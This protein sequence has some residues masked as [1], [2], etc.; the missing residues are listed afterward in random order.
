MLNKFLDYDLD[1]IIIS[2]KEEEPV[3][4]DDITE[5]NLDD[6]LEKEE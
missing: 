3:K 1:Y 5:D 4:E 6:V 2:D